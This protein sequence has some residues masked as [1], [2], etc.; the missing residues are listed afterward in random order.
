MSEK[1]KP[2]ASASDCENCMF[3]DY[4]DDEG[5]DKGCLVSM[6]EDERSR[7]L[8]ESRARCPYFRFYDEYK[9]VRKQN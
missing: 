3:F 2:E 9:F 4:L 1:K 6:D 5:S 7:L 8:G